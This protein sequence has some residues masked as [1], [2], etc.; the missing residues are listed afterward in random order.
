MKRTTEI[1][2]GVT[3]VVALV[4][5]IWGVTW[6]REFKIGR[7]VRLWT[8]SFP[9]T[10]GLGPSDEVQVNGIRKGSVSSIDLAGDHVVVHLALD[11]DLELTHDSRVSIRNVG[12]MGEKV[13]AVDLH[14]TGE[15]YTARDTIPGVFEP[16]LGEF[17][18][19][20]GPSFDAMNRVIV[21]LDRLATRL[22]RNGE[23]DRTIANL[24]QTSDE[25]LKATRE[26]RAIVNETLRNARDVSRTAKA[27]TTDQE[28]HLRETIASLERGTRNFERLTTRLDSV[29]A[30]T[31]Q[32]ADKANGGDGTAALLLNDR[33]LYDD[34]RATV[35]SLRELI[36]DMKKNPRKYVN[37]S[38]F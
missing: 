30:V 26:N 35:Q 23:V 3:V 22:D 36:E 20:A 14:P 38:I 1:Q 7:Q 28:A 25:L 10:G 6:L 27:L 21:A 19:S 5:L 8:V 37:L 15:R 9:Q 11:K 16:G 18:A 32:V 29:L 17:M 13:I 34:T 31:K 12:L 2:V 4:V 24:R 33:K